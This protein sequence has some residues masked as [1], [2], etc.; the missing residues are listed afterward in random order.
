MRA[1]ADSGPLIHLSWI[2]R[3]GL[4]PSIFDE[5]IAPAAVRGEVL[6]AGSGVPG[7][8]ALQRAFS[9]GW[10][11]AQRV[12]D[13]ARVESL[14]ARLDRGEAEAI[15]LMEETDADLILIDDRRA[16]HYAAE[17]GLALTG[18]IGILQTARARGLIPAVPPLLVELRR[19]GF[20]V[21]V[22]LE[23]RIR[24]EETAG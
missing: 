18:T 14:R 3:L 16:R 23:D 17:Q 10:L 20:R 22:E 9:A 2:D 5:V 7:V 19:L 24:R 8:V 21:S 6:R 1:V 15:V 12:A 13:T 11:T 4:L